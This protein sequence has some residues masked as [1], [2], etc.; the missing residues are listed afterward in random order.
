[1]N[2]AHLLFFFK[3]FGGAAETTRTGGDDAPPKRHPDYITRGELYQL[4]LA[5]QEKRER[6]EALEKTQAELLVLD[7][8]EAELPDTSKIDAFKRAHELAKTKK[9]IEATNKALEE[10]REAEVLQVLMMDDQIRRDI[11]RKIITL[12]S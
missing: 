7:V 10:L 9:A 6:L 8:L 2:T 1:M 5:A 12:W 11:V 4:E 3:N